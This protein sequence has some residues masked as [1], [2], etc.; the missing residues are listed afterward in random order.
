M[1]RRLLA[2]TAVLS[3]FLV[4][5]LVLAQAPPGQD[6][7]A[8]HRQHYPARLSPADSEALLREIAADLNAGSAPD[9]YGVLKDAGGNHCGPI[10]CDII[11]DASTGQHWDVLTDGT[12]STQDGPPGCSPDAAC[13]DGKA[14][15]QYWGTA[16]AAWQPK[17]V[18]ADPSRCLV[19]P[20]GTTTPPTEPPPSGGTPRLDAL[21]QT[22]VTQNA[23]LT[24]LKNE[25]ARLESR[26][27][28]LESKPG[29]GA[30]HCEEI[31]TETGR[32]WGHAHPVT[33]WKCEGK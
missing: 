29:G 12:D 33:V 24:A 26:I 30:V 17:G 32:N 16:G 10:E 20:G 15:G 7:V 1:S 22:D 31:K 28:V 13:T 6:T 11:C 2:L 5:A 27:V 4:F 25:I 3:P 14:D 21:E 19:V 18:L 9:T 23:A 8:A